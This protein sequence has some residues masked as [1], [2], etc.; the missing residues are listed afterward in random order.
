M[1]QESTAVVIQVNVALFCPT[2]SFREKS[3]L[4][5]QI[6]KRDPKAQVER[7]AKLERVRVADRKH[8]AA[9]TLLLKQILA[10]KTWDE[11]G[12]TEVLSRAFAERTTHVR[13]QPG[14][15]IEGDV[16]V[17]LAL[18]FAANGHLHVCTAR[19]RTHTKSLGNGHSPEQL[20]LA[21]LAVSVART[22]NHDFLILG[23]DFN[24]SSV[25][26]NRRRYG[27]LKRTL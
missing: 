19:F 6:S 8:Q 22:H 17:G 11:P 1:A 18:A 16:H 12:E 5:C 4:L 14:C 9:L 27:N 10:T 24:V 7:E 3:L 26:D 20:G 13:S 2:S 15:S 25:A 23:V 21:A